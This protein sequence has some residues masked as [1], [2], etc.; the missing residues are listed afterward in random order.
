MRVAVNPDF[1]AGVLD[2]G[3]ERIGDLVVAG[4]EVKRRPQAKL[5]LCPHHAP[6]PRQTVGGLDVV[7]QNSCPPMSIGPEPHE[8]HVSIA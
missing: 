1:E 8:W 3:D 4:Y 5:P 2:L 6:N 7:R